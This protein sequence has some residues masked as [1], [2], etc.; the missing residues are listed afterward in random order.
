RLLESLGLPTA[1][2]GAVLVGPDLRVEG[3]EDVFA[4]GD[5]A[6][7][8][9]DDGKPVPP[10][11]QAAHQQASFLYDALLARARGDRGAPRG[12]YVYRDYGSLVSIGT[13][14]SVG[15]LMGSLSPATGFVQGLLARWMHASLHLMPHRAVPRTP[16]TGVVA[17]ARFLLS[18][19]TP[20]G[21][22]HLPASDDGRTDAT[23]RSHADRV[24]PVH[25]RGHG[26]ARDRGG[27]EP[28][29]QRGSPAG[30]RRLPRLPLGA[31]LRVRGCLRATLRRHL[32]A[33]ESRGNP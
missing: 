30:D 28:L 32:R 1:R 14:D 29:V 12:R 33:R 23:R 4:L 15:S 20:Q 19:A 13:R 9:M 2:N 7:C 5:C 21:K 17:L 6:Y 22:L 24:A 11:A 10:R 3:H 26:S 27:L 16:R 31:A 25:R 18:R 8:P